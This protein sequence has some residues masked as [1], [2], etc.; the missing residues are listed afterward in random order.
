MCPSYMAT[1][2]EIHST[3]ARANL[4]R[5]FINNY[6]LNLKTSDVLK[7]LDLCLSCKGCKSE[8]PSNIDMA[9]YKA[10]FLQNYYSSHRIPLRTKLFAYITQIN[11]IA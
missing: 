10:E 1:K 8:C 2:D 6:N 7:V 3:R 5:E 9:A 11:K 4:L